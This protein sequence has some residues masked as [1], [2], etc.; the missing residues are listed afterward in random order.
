MFS[1]WDKKKF[2]D[3]FKIEII[4]HFPE[5]TESGKKNHGLVLSMSFTRS[6]FSDV[7]MFFQFSCTCL[8]TEGWS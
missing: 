5:A 4:E 1:K 7:A 6:K 8:G 2:T 3:L